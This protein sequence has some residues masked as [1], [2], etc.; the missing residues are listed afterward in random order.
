[1][2]M[3]KVYTLIS[4]LLIGALAAA[5]PQGALA[6]GTLACT[7]IN[8]RAFVNYQVGGIP[9]TQV[10]STDGSGN[11]NT[12]FYV[13]VKVNV[14][15]ATTDAA[16]V[17]VNPGAT[18][19]QTH[20]T[21]T[22][23]G[24]APQKYVL[25]YVAE[26]NGT[27]S[28]FSGTDNTDLNNIVIS[29]ATITSLAPNASQPITIA[30]DT[31]LTATNGQIA[32]YALKA[33]TQWV[34]SSTSVTTKDSQVT[35]ATVNDSGLCTALGAGVN[36]DV[37]AGDV[38]GTDDNANDGAHSA[39]SAYAVSASTLTVTKTSA[40][41]WDPVNLTVT[42]KAIPGAVVTYTMT[43][44]NAAGSANA[45]SVVLSDDLTAQIANLTFG[46]GQSGAP[47]TS[48][49]DG[50]TNCTG[51]GAGYGIVVAGACKTN[52]Y[53]A[54]DDGASW[55]DAADPNGGANKIAVSGLTV[56]GGANVVIKYQVTIK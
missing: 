41:Y 55:S 14:T 40:V 46:N 36:I 12:S 20:F 7:Q 27:S 31:P 44:A 1:M 15:V 8:N 22:N 10:G 38:A 43:I 16:N 3:C 19:T 34:G 42:P 51:S 39:R 9:Q 25:T 13:G 35:A 29:S 5:L 50:V 52:V 37:V 18:G 33:Q 56:N 4:V 17:T 6:A 45:T 26:P 24:N 47:N 49:N 54:N 21:V 28:P 48:F 53:N 32:V 30:A 23:N 11:N 2:N